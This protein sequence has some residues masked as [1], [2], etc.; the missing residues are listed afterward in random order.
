MDDKRITNKNLLFFE[1]YLAQLLVTIGDKKSHKIRED[2][3]SV[4]SSLKTTLPRVISFVYLRD[5]ALECTL[6]DGEFIEF[7]DDYKEQFNTF[8]KTTIGTNR[9]GSPSVAGFNLSLV[10]LSSNISYFLNIPLENVIGRNN[11]KET[12]VDSF[13]EPSVKKMIISDIFSYVYSYYGNNN[14]RPFNFSF[15]ASFENHSDFIFKTIGRMISTF[16]HFN[17][18]EN[19]ITETYETSYS[20]QRGTLIPAN[21][22]FNFP[23]IRRYSSCSL[24]PCTFLSLLDSSVLDFDHKRKEDTERL[25][26]IIKNEGRLGVILVEQF[27]GVSNF[28]N[29]DYANP[30]YEISI[31]TTGYSFHDE[32]AALELFRTYFDLVIFK[33]IK[34]VE[35]SLL[36]NPESTI[37]FSLVMSLCKVIEEEI[38]EKWIGNLTHR[39]DLSTVSFVQMDVNV[40]FFT[41][42]SESLFDYGLFSNN[43]SFKT[44]FHCATLSDIENIYDVPSTPLFFRYISNEIE[45]TT[46]KKWSYLNSLKKINSNNDM[47]VFVIKAKYEVKMK[48]VIEYALLKFGGLNDNVS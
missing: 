2:D 7:E 14:T 3:S 28:F 35:M 23:E 48:D 8:V 9:D 36:I 15:F 29:K 19:F 46:S 30:I 33:K 20:T 45:I 18:T 38:F 17:S 40:F 25:I 10:K 37:D 41:R 6:F 5:K 42:T 31:D 11:V 13:F 34:N 32:K 22:G 39:T 21:G 26:H 43:T 16:S 1:I 47:K 24:P 44:D 4:L 12:Y 27:Y